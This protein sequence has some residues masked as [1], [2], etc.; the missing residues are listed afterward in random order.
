[1]RIYFATNRDPDN[2][3][4]PTD[5]GSRFSVN[6]LTDLRFG[7]AEVTGAKLDQ[8]ALTVAAENLEVSVDQARTGDLSGQV[9]GSQAVFDEV[10]REMTE[11]EQD[12]LI[13]IHGF[14]YTF[15]EALQRTAQMKK[16]YANRPM[17]YFLFT[18]PSDGSMLPFK[19]YASDRDDARA[20]GV[21]LGRG[22]QKLAHYLRGTRPE[23]YCGQAVH[24]AAHSMGNYALRWA[25]QGIRAGGATNLRRLLDQVLLFAADED[26]D[27]FELDFKLLPLPDMA[28]RV[29]VYHN[30]GDKALVT[31][32]LTKGNPDRLGAGGPRNARAL[33]DKVSVVNCE[34]VTRFRDDPTGHQYYRLNN[35][36]RGDVLAVL[37]GT[38]P[39][40]IR[41]RQYQPETRSFRLKRG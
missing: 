34:S 11:G 3:E 28:R 17:V 40:D 33:P 38:D 31:S 32:D 10:R 39:Q 26:D 21:A 41:N 37:K 19:A 25:L 35:V 18:W 8:Y 30:P 13:S 6:G 5:F 16:F 36:V 14:N 15:R 4:H 23:D 20:S 1:M 22:L 24:L 12:C 7:W 9:L 27:A 2:I 29:T